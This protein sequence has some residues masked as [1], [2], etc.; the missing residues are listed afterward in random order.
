MG[1][2]AAFLLILVGTTQSLVFVY[3]PQTKAKPVIQLLEDLV[4][5]Q[6][7]QDLPEQSTNAELDESDDSKLP[8]CRIL[9]PE[10][11]CKEIPGISDPYLLIEVLHQNYAITTPPPEC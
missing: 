10:P 4:M 5:E 6:D 2:L 9:I 8:L 11:L 3:T 7:Q 1:K